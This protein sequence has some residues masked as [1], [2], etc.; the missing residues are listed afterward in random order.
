[1]RFSSPASRFLT[2]CPTR[3]RQLALLPPR[4]RISGSSP[5]QSA[6]E[7]VLRGFTSIRDVGGPSFGLKR[8]IDEG[9]VQTA[10]AAM[11]W[12]FGAMISQSSDHGGFACLSQKRWE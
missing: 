3:C 12:P 5:A 1:M 7:T 6:Q 9:L 10:P 2:V 4:P 8:A 11:I